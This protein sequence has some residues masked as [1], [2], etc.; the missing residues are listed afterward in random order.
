[1]RNTE[2]LN[3]TVRLNQGLKYF[4]AFVPGVR[5]ENHDDLV[6]CQSMLCISALVCWEYFHFHVVIQYVHY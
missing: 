2:N 4:F 5:R 1:M 3:R 6:T